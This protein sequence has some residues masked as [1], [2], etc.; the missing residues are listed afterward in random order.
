MVSLRN[1]LPLWL[2]VWVESWSKMCIYDACPSDASNY[3]G[4]GYDSCF[5]N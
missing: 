3:G 5:I 2:M 1:P 4:A